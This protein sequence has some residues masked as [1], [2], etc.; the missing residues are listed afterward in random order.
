MSER[1]HNLP[2]LIPEEQTNMSDIHFENGIHL[3]TDTDLNSLHNEFS[4]G[5]LNAHAWN[6]EVEKRIA[7]YSR[8]APALVIGID[9]QSPLPRGNYAYD[10]ESEG[11]FTWQWLPA[12]PYNLNH[13][14]TV[15]VVKGDIQYGAIPMAEMPSLTQIPDSIFQYA[16]KSQGAEEQ[17]VKNTVKNTLCI[18]SVSLFIGFAILMGGI[19][20]IK[21]PSRK[22]TQGRELIKKPLSRRDFLRITA[23]SLTGAATTVSPWAQL[24]PSQFTATASNE[25]IM[26][27]WQGVDQIVTPMLS[28]STYADGRTELLRRKM[29][30]VQVKNIV[31]FTGAEYVEL[32][33]NAHHLNNSLNKKTRAEAI[34][35]L[36]REMI[37][38]GKQLY[39]SYYQV[40][41][42]H[43]PATAINNLLDY[44][45][46]I[47][48]IKVS[49]PGGPDIQ[50][51]FPNQIMNHV[52]P[53][54]RFYS[55]QVE[56]AIK[57]LRLN[58]KFI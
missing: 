53:F 5:N 32:M 47:D 9:S 44:I 19:K 29:E 58:S 35:A 39:K 55:Q 7:S 38:V 43:I 10:Y 30:D 52:V 21:T 11:I 56:E 12:R 33:G 22:P 2:T 13:S 25:E 37:T 54:G 36:A 23:L 8:N 24:L 50:P 6:K 48:L 3:S 45:A 16:V 17:A 26:K 42:D 20:V 18:E 27:F 57:V 4:Q 40:P 49:D 31:E 1:Q 46:Q 14:G 15:Y 51:N 41:E 34:T 28:R